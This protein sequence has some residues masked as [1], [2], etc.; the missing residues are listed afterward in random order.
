MRLSLPCLFALP[1]V[2]AIILS[3][4]AGGGAAPVRVTP[5][6]SPTTAPSP[7]PLQTVE[8]SPA[9]ASAE[10]TTEPSSSAPTET[11]AATATPAPKPDRRHL[12]VGAASGAPLAALGPLLGALKASGIEAEQVLQDADLELTTAAPASAA[13]VWERVFT[14]VDRMSSVLDSISLAE[15][16]SVW[17]G[18]GQT[19]ELHQHLRQPG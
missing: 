11:V 9:T 1:V 10:A 19:P 2:A 15:L 3:G 14:P 16:K 17:T 13:P 7:Q 8:V 6:V 4:C 5:A 12:G 18:S